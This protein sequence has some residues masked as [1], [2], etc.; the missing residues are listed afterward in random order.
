M[1]NFRLSPSAKEDLYRIWLYGLLQFGEA[2]ADTYYLSFFEY[3]EI[4]G[5]NP[6]QFPSADHIKNGYRRC[7]HKSDTIYFRVLPDMVE[8]MTIIGRQNLDKQVHKFR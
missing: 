8:I 7:V 5:R 2:Q 1:A 3:F 4:I 6:F